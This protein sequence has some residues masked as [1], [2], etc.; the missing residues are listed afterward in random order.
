MQQQLAQ[1][2]LDKV[3]SGRLKACLATACLFRCA[4]RAGIAVRPGQLGSMGPPLPGCAAAAAVH[5]ARSGS[6]RRASDG[7]FPGRPA[8]R[9]PS[10]QRRRRTAY[11][12][13]HPGATAA[14]QPAA[15]ACGVDAPAAAAGR[16]GARR[17]GHPGRGHLVAGRAP[18]GGRPRSAV[19]VLASSI[20]AQTANY[21]MDVTPPSA[22]RARSPGGWTSALWRVA[23]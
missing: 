16:G 21:A 9:T 3:G 1:L 17:R 15:G 12:V 6:A 13:A 14:A 10:P 5:V 19:A 2:Q 4:F 8:L 11:P 23:L 7:T 22:P 18:R 20:P